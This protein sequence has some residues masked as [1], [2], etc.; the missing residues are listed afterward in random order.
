MFVAVAGVH[1]A[2]SF[3]AA[4]CSRAARFRAREYSRARAGTRSSRAAACSRAARFRAREY[5]RAR[6]GTRM[7][8]TL[9]EEC[10]AL[11]RL[12]QLGPK[13]RIVVGE[14][15][16]PHRVQG[17]VCHGEGGH[18]GQCIARM[19]LRNQA[20][21]PQSYER[22]WLRCVCMC[23]YVYCEKQL[24]FDQHVHACVCICTY[25]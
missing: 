18:V 15:E 20:E 25:M 12:Q 21:L 10:L 4:A 19:G 24:V 16:V 22:K 17:V 8:W 3:R 2:A 14:V 9:V 5:S 13:S 6:A 1:V 7:L 11:T 23:M